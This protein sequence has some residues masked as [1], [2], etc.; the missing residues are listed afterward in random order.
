MEKGDLYSFPRCRALQCS[1]NCRSPIWLWAI[2][3]CPQAAPGFSTSVD[4]HFRSGPGVPHVA[5]GRPVVSRHCSGC[6]LCSQSGWGP[7]ALSPPQS[8]FLNSSVLTLP[9]D[10]A[11][12]RPSLGLSL[13][14]SENEGVIWRLAKHAP[15]KCWLH[16][17]ILAE[18]FHGP[19]NCWS[20]K[21]PR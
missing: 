13:P 4:Y 2:V 10:H 8:L 21:S 14:T 12:A 18:Y 20:P 15:G 19:T 3:G 17:E 16:V 5:A 9:S 6:G 1:G 11:P 7:W